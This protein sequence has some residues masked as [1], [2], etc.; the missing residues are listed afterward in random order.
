MKKLHNLTFNFKNI[1]S[2]FRGR[3]I[4]NLAFHFLDKHLDYGTETI[5]SNMD[6]LTISVH[7]GFQ[8]NM[9]SHKLESAI[10]LCNNFD[11]FADVEEEEEES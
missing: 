9:E 3:E 6:D 7:V 4:F 2:Y 10:E 1:N 8:N 11:L 5:T